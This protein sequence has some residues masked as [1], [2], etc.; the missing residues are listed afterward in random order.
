MTNGD[1]TSTSALVKCSRAIQFTL[2][3]R[4]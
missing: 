4:V 2:L 1:L 3:Q